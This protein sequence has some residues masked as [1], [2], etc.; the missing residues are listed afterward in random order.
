VENH[1][2]LFRTHVSFLGLSESDL[3]KIRS[4]VH[5]NSLYGKSGSGAA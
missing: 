3:Q 1:K 4:W 2:E 5:Y